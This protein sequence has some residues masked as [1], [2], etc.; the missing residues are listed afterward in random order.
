MRD[1]HTCCSNFPQAVAHDGVGMDTKTFQPS[2]YG[3]LEN[4]DT[5]LG[6]FTLINRE[7]TRSR[8]VNEERK[9]GVSS[10]RRCFVGGIC[11]DSVE[12]GVL[13]GQIATHALI[14][15][16]LSGESHQNATSVAGRYG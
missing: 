12:A 7:T 1:E 2:A 15:R 8:L 5:D 6:D 3:I 9:N 10:Q 4:E 16:T 11:Y 14:L 13:L